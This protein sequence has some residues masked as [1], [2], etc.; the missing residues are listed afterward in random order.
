M[1]IRTDTYALATAAGRKPG[2]PG[3][4]DAQNYLRCRFADLELLPYGDA[5]DWG[6]D[7]FAKVR[8]ERVRMTNL[9]G[10][11]PGTN[12]ALAPIVIGAHYDS[13]IESY[14]ADDNASSVAVMLHVAERLINEGA[15]PRRD[16]V[17]AAFDG[18]EP[19]FFHTPA[20]GSTR[21]VQDVLGVVH[22]AIVMDLV[23]HPTG[24]PGVDPHLSVVTG[25][26][27][28]PSL[29]DALAKVDLPLL[30]VDNKRTGDMSDHHAFREAGKPFLFLSSGEWEHYHT[31][32]DRPEFL[33]YA[34][35]DRVA[36]AVERMARN[37][38]VLGLGVAKPHGIE[39]LEAERLDALLPAELLDPLRHGQT[40]REALPHI[41]GRLRASMWGEHAA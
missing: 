36:A 9:L 37:A 10:V 3:H 11:I 2:T 8:G 29:R 18:E 20:M 6:H 34:K 33:D 28:H 21:A 4:D 38:D 27:S 24:L 40:T 16:V 1:S 22:L 31:E 17:I 12:R 7:Y 41:I 5:D 39:D 30:V 13:V 32:E 14:C 19:P 23:G 35:L 15:P 25:V 26:E